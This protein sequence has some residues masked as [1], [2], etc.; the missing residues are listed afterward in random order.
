MGLVDLATHLPDQTGGKKQFKFKTQETKECLGQ[1][2][3]FP[4]DAFRTKSNVKRD[5]FYGF[6][7]NAAL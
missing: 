5:M 7:L 2:E 3:I 4:G 1:S 6:T